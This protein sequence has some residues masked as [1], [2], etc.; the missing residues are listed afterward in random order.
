MLASLTDHFFHFAPIFLKN[1]PIFR[2]Y[3]EARA[4]CASSVIRH[5]LRFAAVEA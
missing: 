4:S 2:P 1:L 5:R 3:K